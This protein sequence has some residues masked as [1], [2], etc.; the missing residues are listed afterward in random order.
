M[1]SQVTSTTVVG[2]RTIVLSLDE[3]VAG[4]DL[5]E[6]TVGVYLHLYHSIPHA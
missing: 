5:V 2:D 3:D 4:V 1:P 6:G